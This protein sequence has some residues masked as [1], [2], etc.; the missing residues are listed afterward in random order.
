MTKDN[1]GYGIAETDDQDVRDLLVEVMGFFPE[2][3]KLS[4]EDLLAFSYS[5]A[6]TKLRIMDEEHA[7]RLFIRLYITIHLL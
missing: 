4:R 6:L 5:Y 2:G 7:L 1:M 3:T